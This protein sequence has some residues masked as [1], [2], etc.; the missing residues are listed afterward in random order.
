MLVVI[1]ITYSK[2]GQD[3]GYT[4]VKTFGQ[5]TSD[6]TGPLITSCVMCAVYLLAAV[7]L[8]P[9]GI[10]EATEELGGPTDMAGVYTYHMITL[11]YVMMYWGIAKGIEAYEAAMWFTLGVVIFNFLLILFIYC[12]L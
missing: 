12:I 1:I 4:F 3:V 7:V 2:M 6:M 8:T 9:R 10:P 5:D 11:M